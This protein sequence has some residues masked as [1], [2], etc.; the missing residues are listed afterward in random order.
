MLYARKIILGLC[1]LACA[2]AQAQDPSLP[3][4]KA[5]VVLLSGKILKD[6]VL[7]KLHPTTVE[8]LK[9]EN[10]HDLPLQNISYVHCTRADYELNDSN[11]FVRIEYDKLILINRDTIYCYIKEINP[12]TYIYTLP[13][14]TTCHS[15]ERYNVRKHILAGVEEIPH[16]PQKKTESKTDSTTRSQGSIRKEVVTDD[17]YALGKADSQKEFKGNGS[18]TGGLLLGLVPLF[19]WVA[20]PLTLTVPPFTHPVNVQLY[21][22]NKQYR[23]G[24]EKG[25]WHKKVRRTLVGALA[26]AFVF[27]ALTIH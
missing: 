17:Y 1:V 4:G 11:Q 14:Q 12:V 26:G 20:A 24:Y 16:T 9:D 10:L 22:T 15:I 18:L 21:K 23:Q 6:V 8:Y 7:W 13:G 25:A 27:C 5:Q 2:L 3:Q 19:G